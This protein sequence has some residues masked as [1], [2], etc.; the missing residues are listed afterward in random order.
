MTIGAYYVIIALTLTVE[1]WQ[2]PQAP[3]ND[4]VILLE[5]ESTETTAT[6]P[7]SAIK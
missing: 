3:C 4:N 7:P 2:L 5:V 1:D 6:L